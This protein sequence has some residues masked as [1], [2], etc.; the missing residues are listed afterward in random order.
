MSIKEL[1]AELVESL[2]GL[3]LDDKVAALNDIRSCLHEASPFKDEPVDFVKW[4]KS[5]NI[6]ANDYNPNSVAPPE[7][8]LLKLS[9][10]SDGYT[11]PVVSWPRDEHWEVVDGFH[12]NR[13]CKEFP[14]VNKRVSGYLPLVE[15]KPDREGRNDRIASTI[16]HNRARGKHSVTAMSD[17]VV[18]LRRRNWSYEKICKE[19]G[20]DRD[21]ALRLVQIT[22]LAEMFSDKEF[23]EAWEAEV[24]TDEQEQESID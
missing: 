12:R 20:M 13:V 7:M 17:I 14:D 5:E 2:S 8:E 3:S 6:Q 18:E 16:R 9:I 15:I 4:V 23:S 24:L 22:G 1:T 21:E 10:L 19:L 11:Q